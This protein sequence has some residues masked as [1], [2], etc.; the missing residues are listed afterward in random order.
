ME[1]TWV[2]EPLPSGL[3]LILRKVHLPIKLWISLSREHWVQQESAGLCQGSPQSILEKLT[4]MMSQILR[5]KKRKI[6]TNRHTC[7]VWSVWAFYKPW[8]KQWRP[9]AQMD[10]DS[11]F[12]GDWW[13]VLMR[14]KLHDDVSS[15]WK[16]S[17]QFDNGM[18]W[19]RLRTLTIPSWEKELDYK[20]RTLITPRLSWHADVPSG[21]GMVQNKVSA[22]EF[23]TVY[24]QDNDAETIYKRGIDW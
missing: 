11:S 3:L 24:V 10:L 7:N 9:S 13:R 16:H 23:E 6:S 18:T 15:G 17:C 5:G 4:Q 2:L 21:Y 22:L 20:S 14:P 12:A 19:R 1:P 8:N